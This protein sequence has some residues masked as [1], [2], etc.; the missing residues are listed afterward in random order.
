M[1]AMFAKYLSMFACLFVLQAPAFGLTPPPPVEVPLYIGTSAC[2]ASPSIIRDVYTDRSVRLITGRCGVFPN[3]GTLVFSSSDADGILPPNFTYDFAVD[4]IVAVNPAPVRFRTPGRQTFTA[5]DVANNLV[6][7]ET[8]NVLPSPG[9]LELNC[10]RPAIAPTP[11]ITLVGL[12]QPVLGLN[13]GDTVS[14]LFTFVSS[15]SCAKVPSGATQ[16]AAGFGVPI[17]L[18]AVTF[19]T[20]GLQTVSLRDAAGTT[21]ASIAFNVQ[22][23]PAQETSAPV[24]SVSL[25]GLVLSALALVGIA[26][27]TQRRRHRA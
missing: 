2:P 10:I 6:I 27:H 8:F 14:P 15:D 3:R 9:L 16:I 22:R 18:G 5:R 21:L 7:T 19:C 4:N 24:P 26:L 17:S 23:G 11:S 12:E 1:D 13:C 25:L 20:P